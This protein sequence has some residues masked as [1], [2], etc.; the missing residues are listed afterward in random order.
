MDQQSQIFQGR[1][2][3]PEPGI[4]DPGTTISPL[5]NSPP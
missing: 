4:L 2:P 1:K 3:D 5:A